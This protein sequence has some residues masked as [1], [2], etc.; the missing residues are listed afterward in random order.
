MIATPIDIAGSARDIT[1]GL[2]IN[3]SLC[4]VATSGALR[5]EQQFTGEGLIVPQAGEFF[6][7]AGN[8]CPLQASP[9]V[10]SALR[11]K[12]VLVAVAAV[13][14][15]GLTSKPQP[16]PARSGDRVA[17]APAAAPP[18]A[19]EATF[20]HRRFRFASSQSQIKLIPIRRRKIIRRPKLLPF[21]P[22]RFRS[23]KP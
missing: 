16:D 6:L 20:L 11:F 22:F 15:M 8:S 21:R 9:A 18:A 1:V 7:A 12:R 5:L 4:V 2:D 13:P 19:P 14:E 17:R 3:D 10:A 23:I